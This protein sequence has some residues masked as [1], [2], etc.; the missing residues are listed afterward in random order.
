M[1]GSRA[2]TA[3]RAPRARAGA[4][5]AVLQRGPGNLDLVELPLPDIGPDEALLRVE[6]CGICGTDVEEYSGAL[7]D[8]I[9][10]TS[11]FVPG[12]EPVGRIAAIGARAARRWALAEGDRVVVEPALPC[13]ACRDC[14][15]GRYVL[16]AGWDHFPM[17]Y[18]FVPAKIP[19]ALWGGFAD[20]MYL[21]PNSVVH[22]VSDAVAPTTAA[23]F[24]AVAAGVEW[25]VEVPGTRAGDCVVVL[26]AGQRG[27]AC[28]L[29]ARAAGADPV[30]VTGLASDRHKLDLALELGATAAVEVD[31]GDADGGGVP[32]KV[33]ELTGGVRPD[34]VVD[35]A[36]YDPQ[37]VLDALALAR[38]GG[39]VILAGLKGGRPVPGWISDDVVTKGLRVQGVRAVGHT[40]FR[41]AVALIDSGERPLH[42]LVTHAFGLQDAAEAVETLAGNRPG[43]RP[44]SVVIT[45][46]QTTADQIDP[47]Q[48]K[49]GQTVP[50]PPTHP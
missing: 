30:I 32:A 45:P 33:L 31:A 1:T 11:P 25:A 17:S 9:G 42:R 22:K 28:V 37:T 29:A 8:T 40:S 3:S 7:F 49:P 21:H 43:S 14:R 19:P 16:C 47:D 6:A 41:R 44:I 48:I 36:A 18:G 24:N 4:A 27:L 2:G 15:T 20:H 50:P 13:G 35:V 26:G 39:T 38:P 5:R 10:P 34:V 12:H 46:D 23:T